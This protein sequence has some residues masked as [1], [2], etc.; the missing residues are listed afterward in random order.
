MVTVEGVNVLNVLLFY[1][2]VFVFFAGI[3]GSLLETGTPRY[4]HFPFGL[5]RRYPMP[6]EV[7]WTYYFLE[8]TLD[9]FYHSAHVRR[10]GGTKPRHVLPSSLDSEYYVPD[11]RVRTEN[12]YCLNCSKN[13]IKILYKINIYSILRYCR[14]ALSELKCLG[15]KS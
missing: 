2:A 1:Q 11:N 15:V 12:S 10:G 9:T 4:T 14:Y 13:N 5:D 6:P 3:R 8:G 7:K